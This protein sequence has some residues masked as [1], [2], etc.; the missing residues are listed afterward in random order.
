MQWAAWQCEISK[1]QEIN[2][3]YILTLLILSSTNV[4]VIAFEGDVCFS[5]GDAS[6]AVASSSA[7]ICM[8]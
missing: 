2:N 4:Y 1:V 7:K 5:D 3:I 8:S 6:V